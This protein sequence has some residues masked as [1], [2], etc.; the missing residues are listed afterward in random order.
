MGYFSGLDM[1]NFMIT[2]LQLD[3]F[4]R[5]RILKDG[6]IGLIHQTQCSNDPRLPGMAYGFIE[7]YKTT[8]A[9]YG[10]REP[11]PIFTACW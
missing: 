3:A 4:K 10:I 5:K 7:N 2:Q 9:V 1:A 6:T 11:A 8:A